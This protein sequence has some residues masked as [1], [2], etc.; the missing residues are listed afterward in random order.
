MKI[1]V[2]GNICSGKSTLINQIGRGYRIVKIDDLRKAYGDGS[3]SKE[4][5][6]WSQFLEAC[7]DNSDAILEFTGC[8]VHIHAIKEA[9]SDKDLKMVFVKSSSSTC[10]ERAKRKEF[11]IPYPWKSDIFE[12]IRL[13]D[14]ELSSLIST[15]FWKVDLTL[16]G[17]GKFPPANKI[18]EELGC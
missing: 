2:I 7:E 15:S 4:Y 10:Q 9:L 3:F 6:C 18:M 14:G 1:L 16:N 11:D 13:L 17:E 8:G 5:Y 12:T